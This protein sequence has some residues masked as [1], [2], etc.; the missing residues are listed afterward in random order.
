MRWRTWTIVLLCLVALPLWSQEKRVTIEL[1]DAP[2][3]DAFDQLFRAAGENFILKPGVPTEQRL[4]L[5]LVDIPFEKALNFLCDLAGL[6]WEKKDGVYVVSSLSPLPLRP[7]ELHFAP[8]MP[9]PAPFTGGMMGGP[10]LPGV[11]GAPAVWER[12][13]AEAQRAVKK[14]VAEA[15][16]A[17]AEAQKK[18]TMM[19][20]LGLLYP[21]EQRCP[22]CGT[23]IRRD[24]PQ[25]KR[26][27]AFDWR[28]CPYDG[29][30]LLPVPQKCPKCGAALVPKKPPLPPQKPHSPPAK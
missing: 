5:R 4:T 12:H 11:P 25:C 8:L 20:R 17:I 28:F 29:K 16:R 27:M 15:Q 14:T 7:L 23:V 19:L 30:E 1:K 18:V 3:T 13:M 2:I 22:K 26:P 24:C 9:T 10:M 21:S 6:R